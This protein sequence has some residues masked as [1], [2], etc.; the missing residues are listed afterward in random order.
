MA[1]LPLTDEQRTARRVA[2]KRAWER[3]DPKFRDPLQ[4][5]GRR[6]SV[7]CVS[8]EI[9]QRC[10]LDCTLCYLSDISE[11]IPDPPLDELKRRADQIVAIHGPTTN[12]Q[13]SGGD[14]TLR[15]R[16]EL[17]EITRYCRSIGLK[18]ALLTNG[19]KATRSLLGELV[20]A[21]LT[22]VAF[23]VDVTQERKGYATEADLH[24][25]RE[26]YIERARGL[27][28]AVIFNTTLCDQNIAEVPDL[29]RFFRRHADTVGMASFQLQADTGRGV[30]RG[31]EDA[32]EVSLENVRRLIDQGVGLPIS[33]D[34]VH[35]GHP[36]CHSIAYTLV[37]GD[38]VIDA[39]DDPELIAHFLA[40]NADIELDRTRPLEAFANMLRACATRPKLR[41]LALRFL[42]RKGREI[43]LPLAR[44]R[45]RAHKQSF[46]VQ[47]FMDAQALDPERVKNCSF[48]VATHE[49]TMSMCEHNARRDDYLLVGV[50]TLIRKPA[51]R[52]R[53][54]KLARELNA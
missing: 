44:N 49:G 52:G 4:L 18:P 42:A 34:P 13:L 23:H 7:G 35:V 21:G 32:A 6:G 8:L 24:E 5:L 10:N 54:A 31:R 25:V 12:V 9:T 28:L 33:W 40:D 30:L 17:V 53:I 16:D 41:R 45:F 47:N 36:A 11:S 39:L 29:V 14:P 3:I 50:S 26:K 51:P 43:A 22:D 38:T 27:R 15:K 37:A 20:D 1:Y 19:I 46:F 2:L 48:M